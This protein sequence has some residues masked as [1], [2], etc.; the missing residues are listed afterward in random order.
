MTFA[1]KWMRL[2]QDDKDSVFI[3]KFTYC[4]LQGQQIIFTLI[5]YINSIITQRVCKVCIKWKINIFPRV[6][7]IYK[8][9]IYS[10]FY[11]QYDVPFLISYIKLGVAKIEHRAVWDKRELHQSIEWHIF[12]SET[13]FYKMSHKNS[14]NRV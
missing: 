1:Y 4:T 14:E 2:V 10:A 7:I 12:L 6:E 11:Q 3:S 8:S 5:I 9:I 13:H